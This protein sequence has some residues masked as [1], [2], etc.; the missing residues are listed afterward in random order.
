MT[1]IHATGTHESH[2][3][4]ERATVLARVTIASTDRARS[5]SDATALHNWLA[6]RA[7]QLRDSGDATWHSAD[8]PSTSVRKSYQ[9]GKGSK[10]IIEHVTMSR[11]QIKLSNLE[12]VGALVRERFAGDPQEPRIRVEI[13]GR[14]GRRLF[15]DETI[16]R[17][18]SSR[19][20]TTLMLKNEN[21]S[22]MRVN[23]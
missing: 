13:D 20:T 3:R 6:A 1:Q 4:A 15:H 8:A 9:Q 22:S 11:I 16:H 14:S 23:V 7:Q 10:V 19:R 17:F 18:I 21:A 2:H 5:I 12:L